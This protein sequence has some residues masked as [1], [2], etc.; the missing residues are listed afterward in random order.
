MTTYESKVKHITCPVGLVYEKLSNLENL[1]PLIDGAENSDVLRQQIEAAGQDASLLDNLKDVRLTA[2]SIAI[3]APMIG[4][5][6]LRIIDR[7]PEKC[8][9]FETEQSPV[10]ANMWIQ[11]L[12]DKDENGEATATKMRLTLKA[13]LNPMIKMMLGSKLQDGIEKFADMLAMGLSART[14]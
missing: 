5:L 7:E 14:V 12:P 9:K 8:V 2:D 10:K 4:E 11:V 1:R 13:D 3:P 6:S